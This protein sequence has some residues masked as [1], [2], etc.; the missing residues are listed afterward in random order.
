MERIL[1]VRDAGDARVLKEALAVL[2]GLHS[3]V[4]RTFLVS[5]MVDEGLTMRWPPEG[6][7]K[8]VQCCILSVLFNIFSWI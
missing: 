2:E 6:R 8:G 4:K 3:G 1:H 5:V 7:V